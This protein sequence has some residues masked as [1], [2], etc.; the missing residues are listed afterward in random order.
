MRVL[1]TNLVILFSWAMFH[2]KLTIKY[3]SDTATK[4]PNTH[5]QEHWIFPSQF[6]HAALFK[7]GQENES[8]AERL[9]KIGQEKGE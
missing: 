2:G 6:K 3:V 8:K 7:I 4:F 5:I 9:I 1:Y